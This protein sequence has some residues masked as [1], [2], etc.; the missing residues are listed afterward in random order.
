MA[1]KLYNSYGRK[2]ESFR[3]LKGNT[4][5]MYTCGPTVWNYAHI[6]NF[7]TFVFEDILR[8]YLE[9][10]GYNV[11]QAM[12]ITDVEDKIIKGMKQ[13]GMSLKELTTF[14]LAAFVEDMRTLNV[15]EAELY[16]RA[17]EHVPE[18][19]A[20]IKILLKKKYAY[21][22]EDG[23]VYFSIRKFKRYGKLSGIRVSELREGA[24]V[25]QDTYEKEQA[26]D[27][28]LWKAWDEGDGEVFWETE[29]GKGR[30]GWHIEC[31]AMSM[32]YLG[33]TFDIHTGGMDNKFPHHDNEI[34]QSEAATGR[35]FV[36]TWMHSG[37]LTIKGEE[38]HKSSGNIVTLRDLQKQGWD[39]RA[40]RLF[41]ISG[42]YR[43]PLDLTESALEQARANLARIQELI[44]RLRRVSEKGKGTAPGLTFLK[45]FQKAMDD[46]LNTPAALGALFTFLRKVNSSLDSGALGA[47]G[48]RKAIQELRKADS[49]LG[50]MKFEQDVLSGKVE[51]LVK[52][53]EEARKRKD[54]SRA[55]EIRKALL[56][57]GIE[58]EDT[59]QGTVW[60][61]AKAGTPLAES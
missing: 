33:K 4:V 13:T 48:A 25:A 29:L 8:R 46:D 17:T 19:V 36:R 53:R 52:E 37:F 11:K 56:G 20:L 21:R 6:G 31:S 23:S 28:A 44:G 54:F 7:R 57:E 5:R 34:A 10:G 30:P 60:R 42:R 51:A 16:P 15:E 50:V 55:D 12:N 43:D 27:F 49:V 22:G 1:L 61:A 18:M 24:R 59:P 40:I 58:L 35:K 3:P 47:A 26:S 9:F 14:Y 32:K 45:E 39:P 2:L 38:M 41:L